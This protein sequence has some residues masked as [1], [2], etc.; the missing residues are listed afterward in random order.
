MSNIGRK[1][2]LGPGGSPMTHGELMQ[3]IAKSKGQKAS[4]AEHRDCEGI[5]EQRGYREIND[6]AVTYVD[7]FGSRTHVMLFCQT[8]HPTLDE[9]AYLTTVQRSTQDGA[10]AAP[11]KPL[12]QVDW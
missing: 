12:D 2:W 10:A 5:L 3:S 11:S 8:C 7:W 4:E 1:T 9:P 6:A